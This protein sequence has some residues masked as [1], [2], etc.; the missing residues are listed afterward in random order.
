[1]IEN[2]RDKYVKKNNLD[3]AKKANKKQRDRKEA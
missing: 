1:M 3:Y 2:N